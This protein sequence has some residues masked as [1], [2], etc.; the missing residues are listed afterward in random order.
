MIDVT[1]DGR[2]AVVICLALDCLADDLERTMTFAPHDSDEIDGEIMRAARHLRKELS[3]AFLEV[4]TERL[5]DTD[6]PPEIADA[7]RSIIDDIP[8]N[9]GNDETGTA[10]YL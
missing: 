7:M 6:L 2:T 9:N 1:L 5:K 3:D 10:G 4:I 8:G